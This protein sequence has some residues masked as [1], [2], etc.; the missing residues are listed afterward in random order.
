MLVDGHS[1]TVSNHAVHIWSFPLET[2]SA[3]L[4]SLA[5][6]LSPDEKD[7]AARFRFEHLRHAYICGRGALRSLLGRYLNV[8]PASI[9]FQ[10]GA[11]G[12]PSLAPENRIQ[13]N[14]THA[15]NLAAVAL[16]ADCEI[17]IDLEPIRLLPDMDHIASRFFC[18]EESAELRSLPAAERAHAF[19]LCWTRKEAY[20]KAVAG[21]LS[22][23]LS[24]F[25]V[26][27]HP[28]VP[29]R[30]VH[31]GE[32]PTIAQSWTL[33]DLRL[34][35]KFAA[36]IAYRAEPRALSIRPAIQI[37]NLLAGG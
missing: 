3:V 36:A 2:S 22:I 9:R 18:P 34:D 6:V 33:Q 4:A 8:P 37:A 19:F 14:M 1:F 16:T 15:G 7:R 28:E 29:A 10:Y 26:T 31:I 35:P 21:G 20:I 30:F 11:K 13:F 27:L 17:G 32:S 23:P 5:E 12:K 25:R 24:N